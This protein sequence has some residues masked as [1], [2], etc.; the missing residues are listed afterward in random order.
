M[1]KFVSHSI[2]VQHAEKN[3]SF[4]NAFIAIVMRDKFEIGPYSMFVARQ[5]NNR[6]PSCLV[7]RLEGYRETLI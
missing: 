6:K 1:N 2:R 3:V 4:S 7:S 5:G